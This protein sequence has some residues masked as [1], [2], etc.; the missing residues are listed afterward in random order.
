MTRFRILSALLI[1]SAFAPPSAGGGSS[2]DAELVAQL[3]AKSPHLVGFRNKNIPRPDGVYAGTTEI[4]FSLEAGTVTAKLQ[5]SVNSINRS[6]GPV[7]SLKIENG[8]IRFQTQGGGF[9][10]LRFGDDGRLR[11][12]GQTRWTPQYG[13]IDF[14]LGPPKQ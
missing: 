4:V 11:G 10:E 8:V 6:D 2:A 13:V 7:G 14:E 12:S 1:L 3:V 9:W 5:N